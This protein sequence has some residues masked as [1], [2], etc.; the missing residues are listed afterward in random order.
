MMRQVMAAIVVALVSSAQAVGA[1]PLG[2][3]TLGAQPTTFKVSV[4]SA[5][6]HKGPSTG[7][8]VIGTAA[9]GASLEVTRELGSWVRVVWA[10]ASDRVGY[11]HVSTGEIARAANP[12]DQRA[13]ASASAPTSAERP[14][15]IP[16]MPPAQRRAS[17]ES[18][19]PALPPGYT[20]TPAH[21]LGFGGR[22]GG[23]GFGVGAAARAWSHDRFG[24]QVELSRVTFADSGRT[25]SIQLAPS[26]IYA[27]RDH[28]REDWWVRPY[29]GAGPSLQRQRFETL[30]PGASDP[31]SETRIGFQVFGG[32]EITLASLPRFALSADIG[33]RSQPTSFST[34]DSSGVG[35][36]VSGH[37]YWR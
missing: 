2:P 6:V 25:T 36:V 9:R 16:P 26:V 30:V 8:P 7:S 4:S 27:L 31:L 29:I 34:V 24:L 13:S 11:M 18:A 3:Q 35:L 1:Q 12:A 15:A 10:K 21:L 17:R 37:W 32:G 19:A 5:N 22:V 14:M 28:V 23:P 20:R 33:Y